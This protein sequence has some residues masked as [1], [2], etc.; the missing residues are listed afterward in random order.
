MTERATRR[1]GRLYISS[2]VLAGGT[3]QGTYVILAAWSVLRA[4]SASAIAWQLIA[5]A[6]PATVLVV[7]IRNAGNRWNFR[8]LL[9]WVLVLQAVTDLAFAAESLVVGYRLPAALAAT[10][11]LGVTTNI[12]TPGR[13]SFIADLYRP[14]ARRK[15]LSWATAYSNVARLAAPLAVG[16]ILGTP[17][18]PLWFVLDAACC[19]VSA[20]YTGRV[21]R[22][23]H[24]RPATGSAVPTKTVSAG[25]R[26]GRPAILF[27]AADLTLCT[28]GFNIQILASILARTAFPHDATSYVGIIVSAHTLGSIAGA[29]VVTRTHRWLKGTF[30]AGAFMLGVGFCALALPASTLAVL[31]VVAV[32]GIG[33]GLAL[34]ASSVMTSTWGDDHRFQEKLTASTSVTFSGSNVISGPLIAVSVALGGA[35]AAVA[36]CGLG[37]VGA[38][39]LAIVGGRG[40]AIDRPA[41]QPAVAQ[42]SN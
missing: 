1:L 28:F 37:T 39:V 20:I 3:T 13:R 9:G 22:S 16:A 7:L 33:R 30:I 14:D 21:R 12:Q 18:W 4:G 27:L 34:T 26:F 11:L 15:V 29:F 41:A 10:L 5:Q 35:G 19:L 2:F 42:A 32:A 24:R 6:V 25:P 31:L 38:A 17:W 23:V 36:V 40:W 8:S